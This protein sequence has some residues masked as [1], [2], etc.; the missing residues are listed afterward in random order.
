METVE[1]PVLIVGGSLV[2]MTTALMLAH[3]GVPA[4]TVEHHRGTAIHPRAA[5]IQH[6][7][8]E[9]LRT[10]GVEQ[11]VR[12]QSKKQFDQDGAIMAVETLAGK[13]LAW[14]ITDIN[15]GTQDLSPTAGLF[16]TQS[17]LE[18]LMNQR[19]EQLG[20][21]LHFSTDMVSFTQDV[22]GVTA[23]VRHRDTGEERMVRARY[24][25]AADGSHSRIRQALGIAMRGHGQLS[26]SITI[27]FR[28]YLGPLMR[29]RNL[30]VILVKN[31]TLR[32]FIRIE[33][34]Y[35][36][37]FLVVNTVG[38]PSAPIE[39]VW[40]TL[41]DA[42]D[43][44]TSERCLEYL[45]AALG[46]EAAFPL[47]ID[48][49]MRWQAV[50]DSAERFREGRVFLVG[51]AAH[52]MP[53][54]GGFGG[55][56]GMADA[57][58][59]AWKLAAVMKGW[60]GEELLDTYDAERRP[61][62]K[63][64]TEQAYTRYVSREATYLKSDRM[65]A[66]IEDLHFGLGH[67]YPVDGMAA[68][69]VYDDP[70]ESRGRPGTRAP[71]VWLRPTI[72]TLDL[73]D[74]HVTVLTA[75]VGGAWLHAAREVSTALDMPVDA[76]VLDADGFAEAYGLG[77][78]GCVL[79]RPDGFVAWRTTGPASASALEAALRRMLHRA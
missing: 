51:D 70:R 12:Q 52:H 9:I 38:D 78:D 60:A 31:A 58:N 79:V 49:V 6:R 43:D 11:I 67:V 56:T 45:R 19:A 17:M 1:V 74:R 3:H 32:G 29:S 73:F 18:P 23:L 39:D 37:G 21:E 54:Y 26:K 7:S 64:T 41:G 2:G 28:G 27:Y 65:Q 30:S 53:P 72:S 71:H 34:P 57:H 47:E 61:V 50:A 46:V 14:F 33:K 48:N 69:Q 40:A 35:R 8:M 75:S 15:A 66:P 25:I 13:E 24:M 4:L 20:A 55:N 42:Q 68:A 59:L 36:T 22:D 10:V 5:H 76:H 77:P 62:G 44:R 63:L 16:I